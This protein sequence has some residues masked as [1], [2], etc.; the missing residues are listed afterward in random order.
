[1]RKT[2]EILANIGKTMD[3]R[4]VCVRFHRPVTENNSRG[5]PVTFPGRDVVSTRVLLL[6]KRYNPIG[7]GDIPVEP[8]PNKARYVLALPDTPFVR[9][10]IIQHVEGVSWRLDALENFDMGND[11][12]LIQAPIDL[13][14]NA[15]PIVEAEVAENNGDADTDNPAPDDSDVNG[16]TDGLNGNDDIA[17]ASVPKTAAGKRG[18]K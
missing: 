7:G 4:G 17:T 8:D 11:E 5:V 2:T 9:D 3:K 16:G 6:S 15:A 13:V 1:M 10:T 14:K 12:A 18:K